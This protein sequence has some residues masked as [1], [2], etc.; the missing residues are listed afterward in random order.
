MLIAGQAHR[1]EM[2]EQAGERGLDAV[3]VSVGGAG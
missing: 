3:F 1:V 2:L